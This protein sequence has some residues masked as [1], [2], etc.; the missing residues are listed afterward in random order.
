MGANATTFSVYHKFTMFN[1]KNNL[2]TPII[3]TTKV[4]SSQEAV[5]LQGEGAWTRSTSRIQ[6]LLY[7]P[8]KL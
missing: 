2:N 1:N 5:E 4:T 7:I 6:V 3:V 8:Q